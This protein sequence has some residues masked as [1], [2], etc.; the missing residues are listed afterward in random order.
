MMSEGP[1]LIEA[2]PGEL[3]HA[4]NSAV[5]Q[6]E[7]ILIAVRG[8]T[9]EAFAATSRR[10]LHLIAPAITGIKPVEV[11]ETATEAVTAVKAA[12]RPVGGRL[13]WSTDQGEGS[14]EYPT[15]DASKYNL[16][17]ARLQ[18]MIGE[19][20]TPKPPSTPAARPTGDERACPRCGSGVPL[21]GVFCP[22][23]GL[24]SA[25]PCWECGKALSPDANHCAFCGTPNSEPAV[26]KCP[27]CKAN[28]GQ[29]QGYCTQCGTQARIVCADCERPLR[30]DW[31]FCPRCGGEPAWEEQGIQPTVAHLTGDEPDDPSAWLK[32]APSDNGAALNE[33]GTAA[34]EADK[35]EEA[36]RLFREAT[37]AEPENARF[38][39]NLGV[40]YGA[41]GDDLQAFAAYRRATEL[42]P[43]SVSAY[44]FMGELLQ[45]RERPTEAREM[46]EKVIRIA[47]DSAEAAEAREYLEGNEK[48]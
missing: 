28:V 35:Y 6:D 44:L 17:S 10:L 48:V 32:S 34:Y 42:N 12:S 36:V 29:G 31:K 43:E 13:T 45:E 2:L 21:Q 19:R 26:V 39:T 41:L 3:Q 9:R 30:K 14:I 47:P 25:D 33:A 7:E 15:Y 11:R 18:Q 5:R 24:Q 20:K 1:A 22:Q 38:W 8:N 23:C 46:W 27:Q 16:V 4:L 37:D 40:A